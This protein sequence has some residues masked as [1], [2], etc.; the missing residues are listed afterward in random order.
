MN[1]M[2]AGIFG[3]QWNMERLIIVSVSWLYY[4]K[5]CT[6]TTSELKKVKWVEKSQTSAEK[7]GIFL[8]LGAHKH[9]GGGGTSS[10]NS[11]SDT[12]EPFRF[13]SAISPQD[14]F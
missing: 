7:L 9:A 13:L 4:S 6:S 2:I 3:R 10:I 11:Q 12:S 14:E 5:L 1:N 8:M